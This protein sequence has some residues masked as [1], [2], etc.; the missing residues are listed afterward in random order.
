MPQAEGKS[1][2]RDESGGQG[3]SFS[4]RVQGRRASCGL[5]AR[6]VFFGGGDPIPTVNTMQ[7]WVCGLP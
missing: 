7:A 1:G 3:T 5:G 2:L 6:T 4:S